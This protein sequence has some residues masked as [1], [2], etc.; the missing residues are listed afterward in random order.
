MNNRYISLYEN[1]SMENP[2]KYHNLQVYQIAEAHIPPDGVIEEHIQVCDEI[3]YALSGKAVVYNND[4]PVS[5]KAG[6]IHIAC[7]GQKH[8]I[9]ADNTESF[10]YI[11][12]GIRINPESKEYSALKKYF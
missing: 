12:F 5:I 7:K 8:K 10:R 6:D 3:T 2:E 9:T 11:C 1:S 4:V